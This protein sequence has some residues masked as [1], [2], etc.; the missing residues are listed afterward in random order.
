MPEQQG[1]FLIDC[2][3]ITDAGLSVT[4]K[5]EIFQFRVNWI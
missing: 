1:T 4:A 2:H 3:D 5:L